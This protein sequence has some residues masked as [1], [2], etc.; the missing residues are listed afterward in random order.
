MSNEMIYF[1]Q[2]IQKDASFSIKKIGFDLDVIFIY[3]YEWLLKIYL[4]K[5]TWIIFKVWLDTLFF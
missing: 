5:K 3:I 4:E 1:S 2:Q